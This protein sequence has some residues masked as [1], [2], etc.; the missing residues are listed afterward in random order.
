MLRDRGITDFVAYAE[1]LKEAQ[2]V[3]LKGEPTPRIW[4]GA[5]CLNDPAAAQVVLACLEVSRAA[6]SSG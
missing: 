6:E 3:Q 1:S 4:E 2:P 5:V